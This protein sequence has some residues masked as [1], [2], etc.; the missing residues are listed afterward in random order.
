MSEER[1]NIVTYLIDL[2]YRTRSLIPRH[3]GKL[4][5]SN[6]FRFQKESVNKSAFISFDFS[7]H[8]C[9]RGKTRT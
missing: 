6:K 3:N 5:G 4:H 7:I 2:K 1:F 8:V 9:I